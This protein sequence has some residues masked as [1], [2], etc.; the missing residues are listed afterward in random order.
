[1]NA[2]P[3]EGVQTPKGANCPIGVG[4][5]LFGPAMLPLVSVGLAQTDGCPSRAIGARSYRDAQEDVKSWM[6]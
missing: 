5:V 1:M 2:E 6:R 4:T 3:R